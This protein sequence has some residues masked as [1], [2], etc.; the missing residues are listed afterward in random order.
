M[1]RSLKKYASMVKKLTLDE[2]IGQLMCVN[3][4]HSITAE[5][6]EEYCKERKPGSIFLNGHTGESIKKFLA[7]ANRH[8]PIPVIVASDIEHGPGMELPGEPFVVAVQ[9][10][11]EMM[12]DSEQ[13]K[14]LFQAFVSACQ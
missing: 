9:W 4:S 11:P 5:Q 14:Q 10:H 6:F 7:I 2:L 3:I 12:F 1:S 8:S 13:Q